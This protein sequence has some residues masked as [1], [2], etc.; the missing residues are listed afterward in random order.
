MQTGQGCAAFYSDSRFWDRSV[1]RYYRRL[2]RKQPGK[3]AVGY[4]VAAS[5]RI[6]PEW[7]NP[8]VGDVIADEPPGTAYYVVRRAEPGRSFVLFTHT[9]LRY[10]VPARLRDNPRL[11][12]FGE[13]SDSFLLTEPKPGTTRVI[14]RMR[15]SCRPWPFRAY[16]VPIVLVWGEAITA[17]NLLCGVKRRAETAPEPPIR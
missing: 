12:I 3:K 5:D 9:H 17:R 6:V 14:R 1:D 7:Q 13:L 11:G 4:H 2:S 8:P 15:L 10:L 16:A